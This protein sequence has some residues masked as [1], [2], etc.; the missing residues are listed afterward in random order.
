MLSCA[1][2]ACTKFDCY[3]VIKWELSVVISRIHVGLLFLVNRECESMIKPTSKC[4][5]PLVAHIHEA[6]NTH[7]MTWPEG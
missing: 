5:R 3:W 1:L 6:D 2:K 7:L 4:S